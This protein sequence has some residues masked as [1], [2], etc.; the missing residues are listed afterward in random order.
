[1]FPYRSQQKSYR[2]Q[3]SSQFDNIYVKD[4]YSC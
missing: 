3:L 1:M 2:S 4:V